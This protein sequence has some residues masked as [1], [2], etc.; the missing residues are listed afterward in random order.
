MDLRIL[1][2]QARTPGDPILA[3]EFECFARAAGVEESAFTCLN[4]VETT[5]EPSMLDGHALVM[6]GGSGDYSVVK[7]G[8]EWHEPLL[9]MMRAVVEAKLPMFASCF[10]FQSL[11]Q[12]LGGELVS[13]P[14]LA[15]IGTME[16]TLTE[17]GERDPLFGDLPKMFH[18]QLGH[19]DSAHT[20]PDDL[21]LLAGSARCPHQAV[22]HRSAP[23]VAT[24]FHPELT[25]RD[26]ITRYL[27]YLNAY[28]AD[29][30]TPDEAIALAESM[31]Q[32]SPH[33]NALVRQF[34][35]EQKLVSDGSS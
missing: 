22:R 17:A 23:I 25:D 3:H 18:A 26:N 6:V 30:L 34:L 29:E 10:G 13:D 28:K 5:P 19:N 1:L 31:H 14:E 20:L 9:E 4:M 15:E 24:Q 16:V 35:L 32:P 21:I 8:F 27:R 7:G 12:A 11:V 33:A 2:L